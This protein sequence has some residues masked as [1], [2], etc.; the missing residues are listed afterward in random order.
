MDRWD[1]VKVY[2]GPTSNNQMLAALTGRRTYSTSPSIFLDGVVPVYAP[3]VIVSSDNQISVI[4]STDAAVEAAGFSAV[5]QVIDK[6]HVCGSDSDC[7]NGQCNDGTC[8]CQTGFTGVFCQTR[9]F[10]Q[11][12]LSCILFL[13]FIFYQLHLGMIYLP[14]ETITLSSTIRKEM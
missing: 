7:V 8:V 5:F 1:Y 2:D 11:T 6:N 12:Q 9:M 3:D 14:L 13:I 10:N 4:F